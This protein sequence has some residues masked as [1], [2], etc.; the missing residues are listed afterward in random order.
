M[1]S[2]NHRFSES[3]GVPPLG[4]AVRRAEPPKGGTPNAGFTLIELLVVIGIV[5][6][7]AGIILPVVSYV[8]RDAK[9]KLTKAEIRRLAATI[10]AYES[11]Y[12]RVPVSKEAIEAAM[13]SQTKDFTFGGRLDDGTQVSSYDATGYAT[14]NA[15]LMGIL[16]GVG[17]GS[18][19]NLHKVNF[20]NG[21]YVEHSGIGGMGADG[22]LRDPWGSPYFV[23][24]DVD[25]NG[26]VVDGF[27][28]VILKNVVG[29]NRIDLSGSVAI[30]SPGPDRQ[31][32]IT[33]RPKEGVN[34]DN[35]V[36][37]E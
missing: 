1:S 23:T 26:T 32:S 3:F 18:R 19:Y 14:N 33:A 17:S 11:H 13:A 22:V 29:T 21:S 9:V 12:G 34:R 36:S 24:L 6:V 27:Y 5:G 7:L 16:Q 2:A 25:Q 10:A 8:R 15:E 37:W 35:V 30:W 20:V 28:G 31:A 4:G